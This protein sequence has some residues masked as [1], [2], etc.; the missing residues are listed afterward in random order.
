MGLKSIVCWRTLEDNLK[1]TQRFQ[2]DLTAE[3]NAGD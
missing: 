3:Q 2:D 1:K